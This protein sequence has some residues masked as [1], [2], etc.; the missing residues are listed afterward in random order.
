MRA[1]TFASA[2][3]G[4][5]PSTDVISLVVR[6]KQVSVSVRSVNTLFTVWSV[7]NWCV[8]TRSLFDWLCAAIAHSAAQVTSSRIIVRI[9][10][11][12]T[13]RVTDDRLVSQNSTQ[14][15]PLGVEFPKARVRYQLKHRPLPLFN[16]SI[17]NF[18]PVLPRPVSLCVPPPTEIGVLVCLPV[19]LLSE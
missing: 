7:F 19:C 9:S 5:T 8:C 6:C 18:N 11:S 2:A 14:S 1:S 4:E 17:Q 10:D 15:R 3:A 16:W 13:I 12:H